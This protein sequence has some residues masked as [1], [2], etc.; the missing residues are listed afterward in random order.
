MYICM[1]VCIYISLSIYIA[2]PKQVSKRN[3]QIASESGVTSLQLLLLRKLL[4]STYY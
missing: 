2:P 3:N 4:Y 1:Y